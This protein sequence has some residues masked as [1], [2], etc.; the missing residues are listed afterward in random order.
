[1]ISWRT[2]GNGAIE[3]AGQGVP[4]AFAAE[5]RSVRA[6]WI[7]LLARHAAR[8]G[9][10]L[11]WL[12]AFVT[13]ESAGDPTVPGSS[14]EMGLFQ[15]MPIHWRGHS[16]EELKN[17]ELNAT[18]GSELVRS[19]AVANGWELP[20]VA[21]A[22]NAGPDSS[23]GRAKLRPATPWGMAESQGYIA[24]IVAAQNEAV[25]QLAGTDVAQLGAAPAQGGGAVPLG[26]ML[27]IGKWALDALGGK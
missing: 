18:I 20:R 6:R 10:T 7:D 12:L 9:V 2:L 8:V 1:M 23:T 17:P 24:K 16:R 25:A 27:A 26:L 22:Y 11:A 21:S 13:V 15:L 3:V 4:R 5:V 19:L 14:G